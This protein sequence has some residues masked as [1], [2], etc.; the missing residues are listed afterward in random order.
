[1]A[2]EKQLQK[3]NSFALQQ[4]GSQLVLGG[5]LNTGPQQPGLNPVYFKGTNSSGVFEEADHC[6][7]AA[8]YRSTSTPSS[9]NKPTLGSVKYDYVFYRQAWF[10]G[11]SPSVLWTADSDHAMTID[12]ATECSTSTC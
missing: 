9:C 10:T 6:S 2:R 3:A 4:T 7:P 8:A 12:V 5:D 1:M 11:Y